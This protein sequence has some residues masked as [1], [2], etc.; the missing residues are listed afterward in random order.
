MKLQLSWLKSRYN[1]VKEKELTDT[2]SNVINLVWIFFMA[3]GSYKINLKYYDQ[4]VLRS[5]I[6]EDS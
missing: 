3:C 2:C 1:K 4:S 5:F 6:I